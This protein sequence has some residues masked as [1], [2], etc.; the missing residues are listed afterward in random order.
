MENVCTHSS[1]PHQT[2]KAEKPYSWPSVIP[3]VYKPSHRRAVYFSVLCN[4]K[5]K[6]FSHSFS[7]STHSNFHNFP[8]SLYL[9]RMFIFRWAENLY[10]RHH[11]Y[12]FYEMFWRK[13]YQSEGEVSVD[14]FYLKIVYFLPE[15]VTTNTTLVVANI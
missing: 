3:I 13:L 8:F 11:L 5:Y 14:T 7:F 4:N 12:N 1:F 6:N 9:D 15:I 10:H 2:M